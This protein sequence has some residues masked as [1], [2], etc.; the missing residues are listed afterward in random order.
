M[1]ENN[2][3]TNQQI[4]QPLGNPIKVEHPKNIITKLMPLYLKIDSK[5][6]GLLPNPKLRKILILFVVGFIVLFLLLFILGIIFSSTRKIAPSGFFLNKPN[7]VQ[8]NPTPVGI[9]TE[10]QKQLS[11]IR[12]KINDLN[13]PDTLLN[14]PT[15]ESGI[16]VQ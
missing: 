10:I 13:F 14:P 4:P 5:L 12:N 9:E 15:L 7:I 6:T 1:N 8:T 16:K 11:V 2:Q 3:I